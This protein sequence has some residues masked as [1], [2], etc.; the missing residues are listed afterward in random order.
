MQTQILNINWGNVCLSEW[1]KDRGSLCVRLM[2]MIIAVTD[3]LTAYHCL[4]LSRVFVESGV[5]TQESAAFVKLRLL[6][7]TGK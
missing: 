4:V 6:C 3:Q 7:P 2:I 1:D 5:M